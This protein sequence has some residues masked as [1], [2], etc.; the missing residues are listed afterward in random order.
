MKIRT[1]FNMPCDV[2]GYPAKLK[3]KFNFVYGE[4]DKLYYEKMS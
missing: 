1:I 4:K 3:L 2:H